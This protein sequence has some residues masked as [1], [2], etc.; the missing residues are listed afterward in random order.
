MKIKYVKFDTV[1][2]LKKERDGSFSKIELLWGDRIQVDENITNSKGWVKCIARGY[3]GFIKKKSYGDESLLEIYVMDVGQGDSILIKC[4][5]DSP[6]QLGKH[7]MIDGGYKR[8]KLP[9]FKGAADFIDWKFSKEY[10][11]DKIIID[12]VI[13]SHCDADHYGG[14]W[15]LVNPSKDA[16]EEM[17]IDRVEIGNFYHAGV[18]WVRMAKGKKRS[19]GLM[20]SNKLKTIFSNKTSFQNALIKGKYPILQGEWGE[21]IDDLIKSDA[22]NNIDILGFDYKKGGNQYMPNY[23]PNESD[24]II[25]VLGPILDKKRNGK[26][27]LFDLGSSSQ[28]TNGNSTVLSLQYNKFKMLLTGDLNK[29]SQDLL[30]KYHSSKEFASDVSKACHHGSEDVSLAFLEHVNAA[31]TIISSGDNEKH[32]HP[33]PNVISMSAITGYKTIEG[34]CLKTPLIYSTEVARSLKVG[35]P[36]AANLND[37]IDHILDNNLFIDDL[38]KLWVNYKSTDAGDLNPKKVSRTLDRLNVIGGIIYG[39]VNVRTDGK[40]IL[41]AVR[42]EKGHTWDC[43]SFESRF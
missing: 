34:D 17:N 9:T 18:S 15:D 27:E 13:V 41:V 5:D 42:S 2:F 39:L 33:R 30:R 14:I 20:K 38:N 32:S 12:D 6:D 25:K 29:A 19:L 3:D 43:E 1:K 36:Y 16:R 24:V 35:E 8:K 26:I 21:F 10:K 7:I 28:N 37:P 40:K 23:G 4:P 11:S 31:A 22:T